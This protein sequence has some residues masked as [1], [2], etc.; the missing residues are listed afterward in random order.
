MGELDRDVPSEMRD[1]DLG[2]PAAV[3]TKSLTAGD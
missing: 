3:A 2:A 1:F